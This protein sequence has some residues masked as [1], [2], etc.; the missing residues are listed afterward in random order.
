MPQVAARSRAPW[1]RILLAV[2]IP[3][4]AVVSLISWGLSSAIASSPDDDF[5][6]ASI[7][8]GHGPDGVN[9]APG[10]ADDE[11][12]VPQVLNE[13]ALCFAYH[14]DEDAGCTW[15]DLSHSD[16]ISTDRG[17][18]AGQYPPVFYWTM[19]W[20]AGPD[21]E[22]SVI[23]MRV[24]NSVIFVGLVTLL[25]FL[26]PRM[27]RTPLIWSLVVT[28]VPLGMFL[29]PSTN[30]SSWALLSGATLW[31]ALVG[32]FESSG[33]RRIA[34]GVFAVLAM[35]MGAGS[36]ADS[37]VYVV[38]AVAVAVVLTFERS[39]RYLLL[40]I[41]PVAIVAIAG[42]FYLS[43][44]QAGAAGEGLTNEGPNAAPGIADI[45][46][47][48]VGNTALIPG[49]WAGIFGIGF[50]L[51]W[52]DTPVPAA[53]SALAF[54]AFII[55]VFVGL[56]RGS[57]RKWIAAGLVFL[58]AWLFP[59]YIL[60]RTGAIVGAFVQPRYVM[61]LLIVLVGVLLIGIAERARLSLPQRVL[62]VAGLA[63]A[64]G[65][66]LWINLRR[67]VTGLDFPSLDLDN[68]RE[69]WW[70]N[71]AFTPMTVLIVGTLAFTAF[72]VLVERVYVA[73]IPAEFRA[74]PALE[75]VG[76]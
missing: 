2:L 23:T 17:N 56:V 6:L 67:Y 61:P 12:S 9:C 74:D 75:R 41:L 73:S 15:S 36:R 60:V 21:F 50:G 51:G 7:W 33:W 20:F 5:H 37:A 52:L 24:V 71:L 31:V 58:A 22:A 13:A 62:I 69:W 47:R 14:P 57:A 32:Y 30:P 55:T 1:R 46:Q 53:A 11:M 49:L 35:I 25:F 70:T 29:I 76:K 64:N 18:F 34:L 19:S 63:L 43:S 45:L 42:L 68:G 28:A 40:A 66:T 44:G 16:L 27:R 65:L 10:D 48:F 39:R 26:L 4:L 54:G 38:V 8:C 3:L 59:T 72:L